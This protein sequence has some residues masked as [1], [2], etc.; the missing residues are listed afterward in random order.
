MPPK[1]IGY[2]DASKLKSSK[3]MSM[4]RTRQEDLEDQ[5]R[6]SLSEEDIKR[7]KDKKKKRKKNK[8]AK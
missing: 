2:Q 1:G 6:K 5:L 7:L 3:V 8:G 4:F